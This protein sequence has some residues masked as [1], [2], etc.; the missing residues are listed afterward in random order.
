[1]RND[2]SLPRMRKGGRGLVD[3]LPAVVPGD[4]PIAERL[5]RAPTVLAP[6]SNETFDFKILGWRRR[7]EL[8]R[9]GLPFSV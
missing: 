4:D 1:M 8:S 6:N 7:A 2:E 5:I 3:V 9:Q